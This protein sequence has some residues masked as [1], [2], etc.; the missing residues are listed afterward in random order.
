[1]TLPHS[2]GSGRRRPS[3]YDGFPV[4]TRIEAKKASS[5]GV[6]G[7]IGRFFHFDVGVTTA[8]GGAIEVAARGWTATS[9]A[10]I[11]KPKMERRVIPRISG[12]LSSGSRHIALFR[13]RFGS[14]FLGKSLDSSAPIIW[15][16]V[17]AVVGVHRR[18][19]PVQSLGDSETSAAI[20][21]EFGGASNLH[22]AI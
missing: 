1:M 19:R 15:H 16:L 22:G 2:E 7:R 21:D 6:G 20:V 5:S 13:T 14:L 10:A 17:G 8:V 4:R 9:V 12:R 11:G 3:K 18:V